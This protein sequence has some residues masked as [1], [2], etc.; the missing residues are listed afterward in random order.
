MLRHPEI[1]LTAVYMTAVYMRNALGIGR[2]HFTI[3]HV[4]AQKMTRPLWLPS[5]SNQYLCMEYG[6]PIKHEDRDTDDDTEGKSITI[7]NT[8]MTESNVRLV[9]RYAYGSPF[10][11][12]VARKVRL[13]RLQRSLLQGYTQR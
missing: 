7:A 2:A 1:F 13:H 4:S 11:D 12:D 6:T 10:G 5:E 3:G 8:P 9:T